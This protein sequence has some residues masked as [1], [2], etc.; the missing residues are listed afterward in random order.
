MIRKLKQMILSN[1]SYAESATNP[2]ERQQ[3]ALAALLVEMARADFDESEA[4]HEEIVRL[5]A[6]HFTLSQVEARGLLTRAANATHE[7]AC[8]FDFTRALHESFDAAQ[9]KDVIRLLWQLA[10]AD[11][12]LDKYEEYLVRKVAELLYVSDSD[13][14]RI[15]HEVLG[16]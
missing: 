10:L 14:I 9:K 13:V 16:S 8:L 5:L 15:K 1:R 7:A 6:G 4:E 3:L 11:N 12:K 2:E